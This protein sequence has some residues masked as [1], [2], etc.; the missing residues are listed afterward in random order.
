MPEARERKKSDKIKGKDRKPSIPAKKDVRRRMTAKLQ[1]DLTERQ[2][3]RGTGGPDSSGGVPAAARRHPHCVEQNEAAARRSGRLL[4]RKF[5][6]G[7][8]DFCAC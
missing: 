6:N 4:C 3:N 1:K 7:P 8:G 2:R 5:E